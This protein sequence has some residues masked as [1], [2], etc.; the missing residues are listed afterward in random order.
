MLILRGAVRA[1][2]SAKKTRLIPSARPN[3]VIALVIAAQLRYRTVFSMSVFRASAVRMA[4]NGPFRAT[5]RAS[6]MKPQFQ[7]HIGDA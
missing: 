1:R 7:P 2:A 6:L 4:A 5:P 3:S